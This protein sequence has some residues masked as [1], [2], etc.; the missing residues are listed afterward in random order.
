MGQMFR[1]GTHS[2]NT[3]IRV[4]LQQYVFNLKMYLLDIYRLS[5]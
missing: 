1:L 4:L 3:I 2:Y 5:S